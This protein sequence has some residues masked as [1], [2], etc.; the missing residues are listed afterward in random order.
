[1]IRINFSFNVGE[2]LSGKFVVATW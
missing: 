2:Y 1:M